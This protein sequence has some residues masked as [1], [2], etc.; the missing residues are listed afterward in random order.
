MGGVEPRVPYLHAADRIALDADGE[1]LLEVCTVGFQLPDGSVDTGE[2][3]PGVHI[4]TYSDDDLTT[5]QA[6]TLAAMILEAAEQ[7]DGWA[8]R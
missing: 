3:P 1:K 2:N 6:R 4:S 7:A 8:A 5:D